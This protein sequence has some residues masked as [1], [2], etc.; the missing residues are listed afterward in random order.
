[1][2]VVDPGGGNVVT[3]D[4]MEQYDR[5]SIDRELERDSRTATDEEDAEPQ[6]ANADS[7]DAPAEDTDAAADEDERDVETEEAG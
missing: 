4:S 3:V 1:M 6:D 2:I 7:H 5:D